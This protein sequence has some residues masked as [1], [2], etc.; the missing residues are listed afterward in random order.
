MAQKTNKR[1]TL[2]CVREVRQFLGP[3]SYYRRFIKDFARVAGPLHELTR[4]DEKWQWGP[5]Q[6]GAFTTLKNLLVSTSILGHPDFSRPFVLDV[7]ASDTAI[8]AMLSQT[9]ENGNQ[10]IIAYISRALTRPE[11]R[12]CVTKKDMLALVWAMK[13]F[14]PYLYG[15]VARTTIPCGG[16]ETSENRKVRWRAG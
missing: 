2:R 6:E 5:R 13:Q 8:G 11:Q 10:M 3:A 7:D 9:M 1:R 14:R 12:Y 4:K 16:S 15:M